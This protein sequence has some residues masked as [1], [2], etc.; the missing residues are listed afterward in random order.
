MKALL[1]A[2]DRWAD[3]RTGY[4]HVLHEALHENIPGGARW[5]YISGSM[6]VFAFSTQLITGIFLWMCYSP[7]SQSAWESVYYIQNEMQGGWLLR[8]IHHFMAQAMVV[9]LPIHL[10]Q[11]VIA[12][13]YVAPRE[14]N[15][16]LGLI[17]MLIT[18]GLGLTGYLLPWDQKGYWATKVA[19]NLMSLAPLGAYQQKL[20]V[21]G[22]EYGNLTLTR[23]FALHAGVLPLLLMFFLGLHLA[24]FRKH[25][26]TAHPSPT[27]PDD[28]FWPKQVFKDAVG[29]L[30][31]LVIVLLAT[32]HWDIGGAL[33]MNLPAEHRGAEL[34]APADPSQPY[35]SARPEWYFLFLFQLLKK[36]KDEFVGAI[37]VPGLLVLFLFAMPLIGR[38][39]FGHAINLV[40]LLA[41]VI[42]AGWLTFEAVN[43]DNYAVWHTTV[44]Q[45]EKQRVIH[46]E[47]TKASAAFLAAKQ[48]AEADYHR[49]KTLVE[50]YGIPREGALA[51][52]RRDS[53]TMGPRLFARHC[54]SCH[55]YAERFDADKQPIALPE[56]ISA[57]NLKG[58]ATAEWWENI[59]DPK[60]V[61]DAHF[62]G[63]TAHN[64]GEMVDFVKGDDM[65]ISAE[66]R[67]ALIATLVAEAGLADHQAQAAQHRKDGTITKGTDLIVAK[68]TGCHKF[69]GD[70]EILEGYPDLTGYGSV[71]WLIGIISNP[72]GERFYQGKNDRM[73]AFAA[74]AEHPEMNELT[75]EELRLLARWLR[76]D[77]RHLGADS[78]A[79]VISS[80]T[81]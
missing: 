16:W 9:L 17:L 58:F 44:P 23:F 34:G 42:G 26:I 45:D 81:P 54:S 3:H 11:V 75:A 21:G 38:V 39:K 60:R 76:G 32:V 74:N 59:L 71:D 7:G 12:K 1:L 6:L 27:R 22:S 77:D 36:F 61:D 33:T 51:L 20:V 8:G 19:T 72:N 40:V 50:Y 49:V 69:H 62:F 65:Q 31:L 48:Q 30:V 68:C 66:D 56:S 46:E 14:I 79:A 24:M 64:A 73:P 78:P 80:E 55:A 5:R 2:L 70:G 63:R 47:R 15:Y 52:Q 43:E 67:A 28:Y 53:E 25:G 35:D 13:A 57:P 41:L 18:L 10:L 4:K 37:V 29:C